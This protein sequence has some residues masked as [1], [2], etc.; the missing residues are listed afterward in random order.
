MNEV[1]GEPMGDHSIPKGQPRR[2]PALHDGGASKWDMKEALL[3]R[4]KVTGAPVTFAVRL[5]LIS[6]PPS[7]EYKDEA[8]KKFGEVWILRFSIEFWRI[9]CFYNRH[10][11]RLLGT[12]HCNN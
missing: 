11:R 10:R 3:S 7:G 4:P 1:T 5:L 12:A 2:R 9:L 8:P 6:L